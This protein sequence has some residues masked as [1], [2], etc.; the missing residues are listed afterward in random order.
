MTTRLPSRAWTEG[1]RCRYGRDGR[2][3]S[4]EISRRPSRVLDAAEAKSPV[5][6]A[7]RALTRGFVEWCAGNLEGVRGAAEEA[8]PLMEAAGLGPERFEATQL[9]VLLAHSGDEW[10]GDVG[11]R[12]AEHQA[13]CPSSPGAYLMLTCA[14][15]STYCSVASRT[16]SWRSLRAIFAPP[17]IPQGRD[18][19]RHSQP[20]CWARSSF[21]PA[22]CKVPKHS[23]ARPSR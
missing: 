5:D 23:Y 7:R 16:M 4:P 18:A 17:P 2:T 13:I 19:D 8:R 12:A 14:S 20:R 21:L 15:A 3:W 22:G 6:W 9:E 11:F 10:I 1:Q